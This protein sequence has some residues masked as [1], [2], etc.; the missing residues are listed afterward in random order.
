MAR[1]LASLA[2]ALGLEVAGDP[3]TEVTRVGTIHGGGEGA[4][5]FL[6][7]PRYRSHLASTALS[8]VILRREDLADCPVPALVAA[9]PYLA[10]ARAATLLA[11]PRDPRP[12]VHPSASVGEG[13]SVPASTE[14]GP[15]ASI[16]AGAVL[17]EQV[18]VGPN[19]VVG[20][21][22][23]IGDA[24]RLSASVTLMDGVVVGA[25]CLFHPGVVVGGDGF[26]IANDAG[27]WVKVPQLGGVR[28][29]DDVELG[30]NT[31][32]DRGAVEDTVIGDGVKL[33]NQC[34]VAHNVVIGEH[35]V[36]AGCSGIAGSTRVGAHCMIA[37]AVGITGHLE[38]A[39]GVVITAFSLVSASIREPGSYSGSLPLDETV[40]WRRNSVRFR[41]LDDLARR[42]RRLERDA[43]ADAD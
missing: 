21:G 37:G 14:V 26:G 38:I 35:T 27:R 23:R 3:A 16:G 19:C 10:Y 22:V 42:L 13:A 20:E 40:S 30:A 24:T 29:G 31:T 11:P 8:A 17:G 43:D 15:N 41:Q 5:G 7:N 25:R 12:G 9:D 6:A 4:L 33:D 1:T 18:I 36:M 32:V 34:Q 39:D 2:E 28:I